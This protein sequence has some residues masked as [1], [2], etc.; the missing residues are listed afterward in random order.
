MTAKLEFVFELEFRQPNAKNQPDQTN[1]KE[2]PITGAHDFCYHTLKGKPIYFIRLKQIM[3]AMKQQ[4]VI[5]LGLIILSAVLFLIGWFLRPSDLDW[6]GLVALCGSAIFLVG[7]GTT[8]Y[9]T[10]GQT[11]STPRISED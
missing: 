7:C 6:G 4:T 5:G 11:A 8:T 10:K 1:T 9:N 3:D 2:N